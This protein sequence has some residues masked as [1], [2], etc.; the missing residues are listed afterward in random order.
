MD[1]D[2]TLELSLGYRYVDPNFRST[3]AQTRRLNFNSDVSVYPEYNNLS[4][5]R[6]ISLFDI[7]T[8]E[9]I[10]NQEM[11]TTLSGFNPAYSNVLP[12]GD[13]TPNE[14]RFFC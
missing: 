2:S 8:D 4:S 10:Y 3:G 12:Y 13:A 5:S 9:N 6:E 7:M 11:T 1:K 14:I